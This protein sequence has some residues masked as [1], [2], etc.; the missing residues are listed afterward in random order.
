MIWNTTT[1]LFAMGAPAGGEQPPFYVTMFPFILMLVVFYFIL[2]RPQQKKAREHQELLKS[3]RPGDKIMTSGGI[4]GIVITVKEK[5]ATVRSADTKIEILKSAVA[6]I[7]ERG[8]EV[9]EA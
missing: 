7:T 6:E 8:S 3:L 9:K 4:I 2:I 1:A 5:T